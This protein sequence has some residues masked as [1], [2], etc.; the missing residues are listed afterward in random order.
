MPEEVTLTFN[1]KEEQIA[2][3]CI[4][5][6]QE[7]AVKQLSSTSSNEEIVDDTAILSSITLLDIL[8][9]LDSMATEEMDEDGGVPL[10]EFS[11]DSEREF[12]VFS[13]GEFFESFCAEDILESLKREKI[14]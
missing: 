7:Q 5:E 11:V 12:R 9:W 8:Q 13:E 10:V 14:K 2:P 1:N 6:N 4:K 3:V